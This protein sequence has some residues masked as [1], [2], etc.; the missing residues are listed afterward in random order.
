MNVKFFYCTDPP[1]KVSKDLDVN[2]PQLTV[3]NV[4]FTTDNSLSVREPTIEFAPSGDTTLET[5]RDIVN[6]ARVNYFY[7]P[8]F[9]RFYKITSMTTSGSHIIISG[10]SDPLTSFKSD[11]TRSTQFVVRQQNKLTKFLPDTQLPVRNDHK[12]IVQTFGDDVYD[13]GCTNVILI[14][15]G[16]GGKVVNP[17]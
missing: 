3:T 12:Y 14:T 7:I 5:W 2:D 6:S 9:T 8:K 1:E 13:Q 10:V 16:K 4:R 15:A 17:N 11:V